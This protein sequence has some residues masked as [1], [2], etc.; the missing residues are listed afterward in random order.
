MRIYRT[1]GNIDHLMLRSMSNADITI[2]GFNVKEYYHD[3]E[4][5]QEQKAAL[6]NV[7]NPCFVQVAKYKYRLLN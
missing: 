1:D 5:S 4:L 7:L 6:K 3:I 2:V